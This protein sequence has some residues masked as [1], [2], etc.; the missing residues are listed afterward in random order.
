MSIL[1]VK[2]AI[3]SVLQSLAFIAGFLLF[4]CSDSG[5]SDVPNVSSMS[6]YEFDGSTMGTTYHIKVVLPSNAKSLENIGKGVDKALN[7]VDMSM[8]TYKKTSELSRFNQS[9]ID[10]WFPVSEDTMRVVKL[11]QSISA[12]S[13]GQY[14]TTVGPLVNLWGFGPMARPE[15]IPDQD[16]ILA[17]KQKVGYEKLAF[18]E[19]PP[20]LRKSADIYV[21]LSSVAKGYAV[22]KVAEFLEASSAPDYLVEV[23]GEIRAAGHKP[24][25]APWVLAIESPASESRSVFRKIKVTGIGLATSG[26]YRNYYEEAGVRFSHTIDPFTGRPIQHKLASVSVIAKTCAEADALATALLVMGEERGYE[27]ALSNNIAAYFIYRTSDGFQGKSSNG[28]EQY[29][30]H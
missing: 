25:G 18:R 7:D 24:G 19:D 12:K 6:I 30:I 21:D 10:S 28:F 13:K 3:R 17:L 27:F 2:P 11:A 16:Q 20:A 14:D 8:S 4:G 22:D 5:N 9:P 26:D 15:V 29:L 23:G 1:I